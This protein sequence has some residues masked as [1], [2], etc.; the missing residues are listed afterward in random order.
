MN[1]ELCCICNIIH[2]YLGVMYQLSGLRGQK[3]ML[4]AIRFRRLVQ[5]SLEL[6]KW[7]LAC[8]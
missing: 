3:A 4:C 1:S 7:L 2:C 5:F 6:A 8:M